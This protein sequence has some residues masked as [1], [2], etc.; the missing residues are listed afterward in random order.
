MD[1]A[2]RRGEDRVEGAWK[3]AAMRRA[4]IVPALIAV[5]LLAG[6]GSSGGGK[7][8]TTSQ[9]A[10]NSSGAGA[11]KALTKSEALALANALMLRASDA[12]A[13]YK[14]SPPEKESKE[15]E[16]G[17]KLTACAGGA[18]E[19]GQLADV[20]SDEFSREAGVVHLKVQSGVTVERTPALANQDLAAIRSERGKRCLSKFL[21][22]YLRGKNYNGATIGPASVSEGTPPA[23]GTS[24]GFAL[25]VVFQISY[26]GIKIPTYIDF[27]GFVS[28]PAEVTLFSL[29]VPEAF[30]AAIQQHLFG[31]LVQRS[32]TR[33]A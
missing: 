5:A 23:P 13:G 32:Q 1:Q 20:K 31:L 6:C 29:G 15:D 9:A 27:L 26:Q 21:D 28:G 18:G 17:R 2:G 19:A 30:P 12:P 11:A 10:A 33:G 14:A 4:Q 25:R 16:L 3:N 22:Q 24:G 8:S 7:S